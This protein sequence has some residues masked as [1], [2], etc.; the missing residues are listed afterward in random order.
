MKSKHLICQN[1][2]KY[3]S[4]NLAIIDIERIKNKSTRD[5]VPIRAYLCQCG[6]WH[7]TSKVRRDDKIIE[8]LKQENEL[9][10]K[11]IESLKKY[12]ASK[13]QHDIAVDIRVKK[14]HEVLSYKNKII[15]D[16]RKSNKDLICK[17]VQLEKKIQTQQ[18]DPIC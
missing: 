5:K 8:E 13:E 6:S 15:S 9:L 14:V 12:H 7:L 11:E 1:K 16:A 17:I 4:E 18:T 3:S 10:K 2:T